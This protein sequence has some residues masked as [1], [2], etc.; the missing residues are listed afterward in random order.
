MRFINDEVFKTPTYLIR[1]EIGARIEAGGMI[2]RINNAQSRVL[3]IC[4][5]TVA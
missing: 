1:P 3:T 4:S 2:T 5:M